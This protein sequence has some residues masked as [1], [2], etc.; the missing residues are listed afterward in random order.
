M[1]MVMVMSV[2][3]NKEGHVKV[4]NCQKQ[5]GVF[6]VVFR[7]CHKQ[8]YHSK[9]R[10]EDSIQTESFLIGYRILKEKIFRAR[11]LYLYNQSEQ[12]RWIVDALSGDSGQPLTN[13]IKKSWYCAYVFVLD[14]FSGPELF[15]WM[16]ES[17]SSQKKGPW[18]NTLCVNSN[19][20]PRL[21]QKRV[22]A[23]YSENNILL[24][25]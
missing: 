3:W 15:D 14:Q 16:K 8:L 25:N 24:G 20:S 10:V 4:L 21:F 23:I 17:P 12:S 1:V 19:N 6:V 2:S 7:Y 22:R 9:T 18:K 5:G 11:W 13:A